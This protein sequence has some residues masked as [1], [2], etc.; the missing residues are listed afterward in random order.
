[1]M[2]VVIV[3]ILFGLYVIAAVL[4]VAGVIIEAVFSGIGALLSGIVAGTFSLAEGVFSVEGILLG[5]V[6]G[7]AWYFLRR[8]NADA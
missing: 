5:V 1:M 6:L 2:F 7:L 3:G 8:R 4:N